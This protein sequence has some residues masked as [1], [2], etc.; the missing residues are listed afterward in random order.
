MGNKTVH[1]ETH[2]LTPT[3]NPRNTAAHL[4]LHGKFKASLGWWDC[5][6]KRKAGKQFSGQRHPPTSANL[7]THS[8]L[9]THVKVEGGN[10]LH[11]VVP[12]LPYAYRHHAPPTHTHNEFIFYKNRGKL[13]HCNSRARN[14]KVCTTSEKCTSLWMGDAYFF[15]C[16]RMVFVFKLDILNIIMYWPQIWFFHSDSICFLLWL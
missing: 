16:A 11:Q 14:E 5:L 4:W 15:P 12:W 2:M 3:C 6:F 10:Q 13:L 9:G 7:R 8:L 1:W